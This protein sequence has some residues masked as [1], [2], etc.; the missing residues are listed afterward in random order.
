MV[1][2]NLV[3]TDATGTQRLRSGTV[4]ISQGEGHHIGGTSPSLINVISGK[5]GSS[6]RDASV[7]IRQ[8]SRDTKVQGNFIGTNKAGTAAIDTL[9]G[10][11]IM[12]S[13]DNLIGG[14][15]KSAANLISGTR[16][17][18]IVVDAASGGAPSSKNMILG[19][20]IGTQKDGAEPLGNRNYGI[21]IVNGVGN[22][23]QGNTIAYS[24]TK[25]GVAVLA[26][27][28]NKISENDIFM[29]GT[30]GIDLSDDG[31]TANDGEDEDSGPNSLQNYPD[32]K[33]EGDQLKATLQSP[34]GK[35]YP[36]EFFANEEC[37][38]ST[39][40]EG[41]RYGEGMD[42]QGFATT[43]DVEG[44]PTAHFAPFGAAGMFITAT[45]TDGSGNTSEFSQ[46]ILFESREPLVVNS[47]GD[48]P[49]ENF[50]E[51]QP[52]GEKKGDG[53]CNTG[54]MV[55]ID[56]KDQPECTL[57]AAIQEANA[58]EGKDTIN[59]HSEVKLIVIQ[60]NPGELVRLPIIED[61]IL[62]EGDVEAKVKLAGSGGFGLVL[63]GGK[64]I[65]RGLEITGFAFGIQLDGEGEHQ[66]QGNTFNE[67]QTGIVVDSDGNVIG[68]RNAAPIFT[69][70]LTRDFVCSEACECVD[71]CNFFS[72]T[73][74]KLFS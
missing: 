14:T 61:S 7:Y 43:A 71:P 59:F 67:N 18:G 73:S 53:I 45:A 23:I 17:S 72:A 10:V 15:T 49:D 26:G 50:K 19:N 41:K 25:A 65:I 1:Q 16:R 42:F 9:Y 6:S 3:G 29:N 12:S 44:V 8:A 55:S 27:T 5:G 32:L 34:A 63:V 51:N 56:G 52:A 33:V 68:G 30:L 13:S 39:D 4:V 38:D 37:D 40:A 46:C 48:D 36:I 69:F 70:D 58:R 20:L 31:V 66:I 2:G 24:E 64:S 35:S 21:R 74:S 54:K 57:R 28:G 47:T 11:T 22:E 60:S 62:I